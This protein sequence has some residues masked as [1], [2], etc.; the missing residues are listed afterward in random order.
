MKRRIGAVI[1]VWVAAIIPFFWAAR[2][3]VDFS[4]RYASASRSFNAVLSRVTGLVPFSVGEFG[5]YAVILAFAVGWGIL[6]YRLRHEL[7][8]AKRI[9]RGL[10]AT[11]FAA[12]ILVCTFVW[13]WG[14][15]YV[16]P[17]LSQQL[18]L[19][20]APQTVQSLTQ[21]ATIYRD[22]LNELCLTVPRTPE[23][24]MAAGDFQTTARKVQESYDTLSATYPFIVTGGAPPKRITAW[25]IQSY[26]GISGV[27]IPWTA[28]ACVNPDTPWPTLPATMAHELAHRQG[29]AA[30]DEANFFGILACEASSD[31]SVRYSGAFLAFLY[32]A[33]ALAPH[34]PAAH[35]ALW[36]G[37]Q[38]E[39]VA[40]MRGL[41]AH[42]AKYEGPIAAAGNA[43]NDTYLK[44]M[45][46]ED[47]VNSYGRVVDL[48]LAKLIADKR[49]VG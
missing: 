37:L 21:A 1:A 48:L 45:L 22:E 40:D 13:F 33:N 38:P 14:L 10:L 19:S 35:S 42:N 18:G 6:L 8:P 16:C 39:V 49:I 43:V 25:F 4:D 9:G 44:V 24:T 27:Y 28:E 29:A 15:H 34:D 26:T 30:E 17:P 32:T 23:G 36:E 7:S 2:G 47:G 31:E 20:P 5:V 12:G 41:V 11:A 46:Q 3:S